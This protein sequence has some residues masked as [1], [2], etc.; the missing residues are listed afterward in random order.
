MITTSPPAGHGNATEHMK[1][2]VKI[3]PDNP[4]GKGHTAQQRTDVC[5]GCHAGNR[6]LA[7][8]AL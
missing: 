3:K 8:W 6:N 1:D 4:F 2:P 5:L 7:V